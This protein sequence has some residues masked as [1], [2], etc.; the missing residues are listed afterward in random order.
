MLK[1]TQIEEFRKY[2]KKSENPLF[3]FDDDPDGLC[4]YLIL[5]KY[6]DK[7]KGAVLKTK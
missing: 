4:S 1:K 6:I 3:F 5:K 7:G 2:L